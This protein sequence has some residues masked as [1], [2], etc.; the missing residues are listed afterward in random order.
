MTIRKASY[1]RYVVAY[2]IVLRRKRTSSLLDLAQFY[3]QLS[4]SILKFIKFSRLCHRKRNLRSGQ[5]HS[6]SP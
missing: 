1:N 3:M 5:I 6:C 2:E 4:N